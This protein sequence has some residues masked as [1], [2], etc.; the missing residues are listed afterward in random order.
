[1]PRS[2]R[3]QVRR[4]AEER[5]EY[6]GFRESHLPLWVFHL[7]HIVARQHRGQDSLKNLAWSCHRCNLHKGTN[8]TG[9]D[10]DSE[11][12]VRL[13]N[14]R[15]DRWGKHFAIRSGRIAGLTATGRATVWLL[16]MN[17]DE[18]VTLRAL[19][20]EDGTW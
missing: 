8:L 16:Q 3:S 9:V 5:C 13:F 14:P 17:S 1:M 15:T 7:D 2:L 20:L 19:L 6:C 12:I 4:R 18:R 10:P 11:R